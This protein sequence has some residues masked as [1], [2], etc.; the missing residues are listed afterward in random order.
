MALKKLDRVQETTTSTGTGGLTLAGATTRMRAFSATMS[1]GDTAYCLIE[2]QSANE[3]EISLCTYNSGGRP[4]RHHAGAHRRRQATS[5]D[6]A[7]LS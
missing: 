5:A 4:H 6:Q 3:W 1:N 2:N 7:G